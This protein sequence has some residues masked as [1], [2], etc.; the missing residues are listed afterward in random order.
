M[1]GGRKIN[2]TLIIYQAKRREK[3]EKKIRDQRDFSIDNIQN[4][5]ENIFKYQ[6]KL[7]N[8]NEQS[9]TKPKPNQNGPYFT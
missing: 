4:G 2:Q 5:I 7:L 8:E 6:K 1:Y 3:K 9:Q